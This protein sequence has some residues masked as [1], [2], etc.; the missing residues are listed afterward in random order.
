MS[1]TIEKLNHLYLK[2]INETLQDA[3]I[4]G[5][6]IQAIRG[7]RSM[8]YHVVLDNPMH[9][10]KLLNIAEPLALQCDTESI[11]MARQRGIVQLFVTLPEEF[12]KVYYRQKD[13][14]G[15]GIG[16]NDYREQVS[17]NFDTP[18]SMF[19]GVTKTGKSYTI[20]ASLLAMMD[21]YDPEQ[22]GIVL[23][24]YHGDA[25][26]FENEIHVLR[27]P[28]GSIAD[29][30]PNTVKSINWVYNLLL[31]RIENKI[32]NDKKIW[33]IV[34]EAEALSDSYKH[35]I[36]Q[37][38]AI[39][40]E[41]SKFGVHLSISCKHPTQ[42]NLPGLL[43]TIGNRFVGRIE[44]ARQTSNRLIGTSEI[45]ARK[46]TRPGD[47]IHSVDGIINR[48][49]VVRIQDSDIK[50]LQRDANTPIQSLDFPKEVHPDLLRTPGRPPD[51]TNQELLAYLMWNR[52]GKYGES[53][54]E[55]IRSIAKIFNTSRYQVNKHEEMV[56]FLISK[57]MKYGGIKC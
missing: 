27:F 51:E 26:K 52:L 36:N 10:P 46:L 56:K 34:D 4:E 2:V 13:V 53:P 22:L 15:A 11:I 57:F 17:F 21:T 29:T 16:L 50:R 30:L 18:H 43:P 9:L 25:Q 28:W 32:R 45:D 19:V 39:G 1:F 5:R 24:D 37:L 42:E 7:A 44:L 55:S 20:A 31:H 12:W 40:N 33:L 35:A 49:L 38:V 6:P 41:G 47:F 23:T 54:K 48:F 14:K 8:V 3:K